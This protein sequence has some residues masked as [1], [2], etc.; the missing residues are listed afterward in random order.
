MT[1]LYAVELA[2]IAAAFAGMILLRRAADRAWADHQT[3][4]SI[5]VDLVIDTSR[6]ELAL[7]QTADAFG[8]LERKLGY[9]R[10]PC[11]CLEAAEHDR[12]CEEHPANRGWCTHLRWR[13]RLLAERWHRWRSWRLTRAATL[14]DTA[15]WGG[16]WRR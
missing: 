14:H 5:R 16:R 6:Y 10:R 9:H 15:A 8:V 1:T 13:S 2:V 7:R 3:T 11:G 12:D 4:G